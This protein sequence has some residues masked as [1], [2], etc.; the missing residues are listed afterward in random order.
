M[1][2]CYTFRKNAAHFMNHFNIRKALK[3][4]INKDEFLCIPSGLTKMTV[5][6]QFY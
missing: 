1:M 4:A 6:F 5:M 2:F 3:M